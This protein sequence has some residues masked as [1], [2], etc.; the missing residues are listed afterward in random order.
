MYYHATNTGSSALAACDYLGEN[1]AYYLGITSP[2][3]HYEIEEHKRALQEVSR[4]AYLLLTQPAVAVILI[5]TL[6]AE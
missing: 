1:I 5:D 4:A 3:F 2:K 6:C